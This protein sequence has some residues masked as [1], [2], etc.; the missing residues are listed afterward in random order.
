MTAD[1]SDLVKR[2]RA[3]QLYGSDPAQAADA[4]EALAKE[5]TRLREL[6]DLYIK[7]TTAGEAATT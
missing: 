1:Y 2:L 5:N 7:G 4:I 3:G 6:V